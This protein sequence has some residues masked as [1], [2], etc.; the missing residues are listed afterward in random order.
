MSVQ[1][2][3]AA[4]YERVAD[5]HAEPQRSEPKERQGA[6]RLYDYE[7]PLLMQIRQKRNELRRDGSLLARYFFVEVQSDQ[8]YL[9]EIPKSERAALI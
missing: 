4:L 9:I 7:I 2:G 5:T 1:Y 3:R 8:I 6:F